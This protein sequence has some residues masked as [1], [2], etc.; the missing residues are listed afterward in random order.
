M[1][2]KN[3]DV[4]YALV[5]DHRRDD[6]VVAGAPGDL[7]GAFIPDLVPLAVTRSALAA[8]SVRAAAIMVR[9]RSWL[10]SLA[11]LAWYSITER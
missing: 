11:R 10:P 7:E 4:V 3:P 2:T 6:R 8:T 9:R 1:L 5:H